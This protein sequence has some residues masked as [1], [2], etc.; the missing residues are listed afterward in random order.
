MGLARSQYVQE[1]QEGVYRCSSRCVRRV[2]L[3]GLDRDSGRDFSRRKA[4]IV[5]RLRHLAA[6]LSRGLPSHRLSLASPFETTLCFSVDEKNS[7]SGAH[8]G[9]EHVWKKY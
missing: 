2:F 8:T 7:Q 6:I 4:W 9:K 1:G 3:C 5:D